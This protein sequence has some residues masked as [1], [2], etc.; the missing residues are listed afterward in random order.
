M[1]LLP[2]CYD[3]RSDAST[4]AVH[5]ASFGASSWQISV[6]VPSN[7]L[8]A[9]AWCLSLFWDCC[10]TRVLEDF[11]AASLEMVI[12]SLSD[13]ASN[14]C[15]A[16]V[17]VSPLYRAAAGLSLAARFLRHLPRTFFTGC[18]APEQHRRLHHISVASECVKKR[19]GSFARTKRESWIFVPAAAPQT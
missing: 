15:N 9:S 11:Q 5:A 7:P 16:T 17:C 18:I 4:C 19:A 1:T 13:H 12:F 14:E 10:S 3:S 6:S 8:L 2:A